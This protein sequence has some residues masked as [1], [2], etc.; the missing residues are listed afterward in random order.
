VCVCV[1]LI[2]VHI[3]IFTI[4]RCYD[5]ITSPLKYNNNNDD[6]NDDDDDDIEYRRYNIVTTI[7]I[8]RDNNN[9]LNKNDIGFVY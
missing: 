2:F 3:V 7:T 9:S 6:G 5:I 8:S 1:H 4:V